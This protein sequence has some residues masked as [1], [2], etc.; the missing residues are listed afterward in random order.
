MLR[1]VSSGKGVTTMTT[2]KATVTQYALDD[3]REVTVTRAGELAEDRWAV[4]ARASRLHRD[5]LKWRAQNA[6]VPL[7]RCPEWGYEPMPSS[8]DDGYVREHTFTL[9]EALAVCE[10]EV[11][12]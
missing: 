9:A 2:T 8:R 5:A 11:E 10:A 4:R 12:P 7:A 1:G 3:E 6:G